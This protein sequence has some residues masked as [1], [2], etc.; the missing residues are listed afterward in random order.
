[1]NYAHKV[2]AFI[3]F[4]SKIYSGNFWI[5]NIKI[6]RFLW[7]HNIVRRFSV[8][9][10][11]DRTNCSIVCKIVSRKFNRYVSER[12]NAFF[13]RINLCPRHI[14]I[15]NDREIFRLSDITGFVHR[16]YRKNVKSVPL[17]FKRIWRIFV[18]SLGKLYFLP[19]WLFICIQQ[20]LHIIF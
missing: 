9:I 19:D 14:F 15:Q 12:R 17:V 1:M 6:L 4:M 18:H 10:N 2:G 3:K 11:N 8:W 5:R 13:N 20:I 7:N 16:G